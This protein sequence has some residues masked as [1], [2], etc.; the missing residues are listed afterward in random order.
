M[1]TLNAAEFTQTVRCLADDIGLQRLRDK[2]VRLNAL[3]ARG[4]A[5]SAEALADQLYMLTGGLRRQVPATIAVQS[6][7]SEQVTQRL[8]EEGE[9]ALE[10]VAEK[11][12]A[13]LGEGDSV[14]PE[15]EAELDTLLAEYQRQLAEKLGPERARIDMLLKAVPAVAAKLRAMPVATAPPSSAATE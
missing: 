10:E 6:L 1:A 2:L 8:G 14:N 13:C 9:K 5:P 7:W 3:V 4:R 15:K 11:I 12:N